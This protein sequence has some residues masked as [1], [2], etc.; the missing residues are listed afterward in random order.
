MAKP[1]VVIVGR[2][3]V[4]KSTLFNRIVGSQA[5]IVEDVPGVTRDRNYMDA[6]WEGRSFV[7]VDTGGFY[8]RPSEDIFEQMREQALFA[9]DE[10]NLIIHLLDGKEGVNP[11]DRELADLLRTSGKK[12]IWAVNKVDAPSREDR[13]YD[14]YSMGLE[15][16]VPVSAATGYNFDELMDTAVS[17]LPAYEEEEAE[18]P[19][20]AVIGRPNAG[21]STLINSLLGKRRLLVSE[22]PG[23]TRDS[24]DSLCTYYRRKYLLIDTAGIRRKDRAGYSIARFAMLRAMRSIERSDVSV[25]VLDASQGIVS[26][27]QKIAGMVERYEKG[28]VFLL[29]KWD[30]VSDPEEARKRLMEDFTRKLWFFS[31]A[32]VLTVSGLE[33]KRTTSILPAIDQV[34]AERRKRVATAELNRFLSGI[35]LPPYRGRKVKLLYMTQVGSEPPRF[36]LFTNNPEGL[37]SSHLR[38]IETRLREVYSFRGTPIRIFVKRKRA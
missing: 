31:H 7:V 25:V 1:T 4:G 5:A 13:L 12:V 8:V 27:D 33:R 10:A 24:I 22:E 38:H 32:P 28:A 35:S 26:D 3:N 29:N 21:K 37:K 17:Y 19:R 18:Y 14:F 20:V 36:A 9:I 11:Y 23:T 2:P 6:Q 16:L 34:M 30:M 15:E